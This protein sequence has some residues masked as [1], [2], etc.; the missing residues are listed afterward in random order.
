[1]KPPAST[2]ASTAGY[3]AGSTTTATVLWFFR[4][5]DHR[6]AADVDLRDALGRC[7]AGG[8]GLGERVQVHHRELERFDL[9]LFE[10]L[11]VRG[12]LPVGE[13]ARVDPRVER[14]HPAVQALGEAGEGLHLRDRHAEGRDRGGRAAG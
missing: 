5:A 11:D 6:R 10:L 13:Q 8:D 9:Q 12:V 14:L 3:S 2:A 7:G 4:R 1:V